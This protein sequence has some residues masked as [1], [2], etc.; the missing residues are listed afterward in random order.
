MVLTIY[1]TA[2]STLALTHMVPSDELDCGLNRQWGRLY[3][4]K[5]AGAIRRIQDAYQCCGFS[6]TRDRPWPFQD[7]KHKIDACITAFNRTKGCI[8]DW[9]QDE[10]VFAGLLL[11]VASTT[12]VLKV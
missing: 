6:G 11:F 12:L 10:Q 4:R 3:S 9:R 5:D 1:E 7:A 8:R 2:I